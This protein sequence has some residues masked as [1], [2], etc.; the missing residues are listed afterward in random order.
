MMYVLS[1]DFLSKGD[2]V[3]FID[4]FLANGNAAKGDIIDFGRK[5]GADPEWGFII[6]KHPN[7]AE[8]ICVM[9]VSA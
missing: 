7:M 8:I 5:V 2:R 9:Q 6:E 1:K 4:D 3:L